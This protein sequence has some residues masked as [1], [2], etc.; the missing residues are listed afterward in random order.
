MYRCRR[1]HRLNG[2]LARAPWRCRIFFTVIR[3]LTL[4][5]SISSWS[6]YLQRRPQSVFNAVFR[7]RR[8]DYISDALA[9]LHWLRIHLNASTLY[10]RCDCFSCAGRSGSV[11]PG[12]AGSTWPSA[13]TFVNITVPAHRLAT[14]GR[15]SFPLAASIVWNSFLTTASPVIGFISVFRRRLNTYFYQTLLLS[16]NLW[17]ADLCNNFRR[18]A[19]HFGFTLI[20]FASEK[21]LGS[22]TDLGLCRQVPDDRTVSYYSHTRRPAS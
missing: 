15:R 8:H 20:T 4:V 18:I 21:T 16:Y 13:P 10:S 7:L 12:S 14:V 6:G 22:A 5:I 9:S 17:S 1:N 3:H 11:I 2:P 19:K